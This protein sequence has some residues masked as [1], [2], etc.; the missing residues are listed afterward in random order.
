MKTI[1]IPYNEKG[2]EDHVIMC[3][4]GNKKKSVGSLCHLSYGTK[5]KMLFTKSTAEHI[6][7]TGN[8]DFKARVMQVGSKTLEKL[9][10]RERG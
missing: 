3:Y 6:V 2:P 1:T 9:K 7:A 5:T 4:R 10:K 8:F